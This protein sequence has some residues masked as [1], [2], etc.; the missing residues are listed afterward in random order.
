MKIINKDL[1]R[2]FREPGNCEF[3]GRYCKARE[4]HHWQ[5][6]GMGNGCQ[7]DVRFNLICVGSTPLWQCTCHTQMESGEIYRRD[8]L[9]KIAALNGLLQDQVER[10]IFILVRLPKNTPLEDAE[11]LVSLEFGREV[12]L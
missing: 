6:K 9:A 8:V 3:C 2:A 11:R 4:A 10:A 1:I 12:K 5:P 7:L